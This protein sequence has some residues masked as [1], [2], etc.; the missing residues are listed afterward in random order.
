M[1]VFQPKLYINIHRYLESIEIV[2]IKIFH[3]I[4][5]IIVLQKYEK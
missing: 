2:Y 5:R 1:Y 3:A 4:F